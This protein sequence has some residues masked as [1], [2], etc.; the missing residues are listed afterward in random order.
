[1]SPTPPAGGSDASPSAARDASH[2]AAGLTALV[3]RKPALLAGV[4]G[5]GVVLFVAMR[6]GSGSSAGSAGMS[7]VPAASAGGTYDSTANDVYNSL[8][9]QLQGMQAEIDALG[10]ASDPTDALAPTK[11]PTAPAPKKPAKP[12]PKKKPA[13]HHTTKKTVHH[14]TK[15]ATHHA[16]PKKKAPVKKKAPAKKPAPVKITPRP[17]AVTHSMRRMVLHRATMASR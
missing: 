13:V 12:A 10:A 6:G 16:A 3:K 11:K 9:G 5:V 17:A 8:A 4:A 7:T 14:T 1:M 2:G 15:K